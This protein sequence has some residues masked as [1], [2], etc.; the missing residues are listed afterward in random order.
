MKSLEWLILA[1][2]NYAQAKAFY[3]KIL[4]LPIVRDISQE[5]FTQFKLANCFLAIYGKKEF[6][7]LLG[8]HKLS[9]PGAAIYTFA[10]VA[11]VIQTYHQLQAK[12]VKFIQPPKLQPWG[13]ITAYFT[14]PDGHIWEIQTWTKPQN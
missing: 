10:Q 6:Q 7:K 13:Q 3:S 9:R 5:H 4:G 2:N 1:T 8:G 14:D 12:G 11:D